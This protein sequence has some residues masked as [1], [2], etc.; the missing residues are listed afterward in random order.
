[1]SLSFDLIVI[2]SGPAGQKCALAAAK[3]GKRVAL[4]DRGQMMGGVCI[5]TGTIPS[6]A[7]R[8][9]VAD[10]V[11]CR[12]VAGMLSGSGG[13]D[14]GSL[15]KPGQFTMDDLLFR[16]HEVIRTER[17]VVRDQMARNNV[18]V[19]DGQASFL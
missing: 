9:A 11:H 16:C 4:V 7:M 6:K 12:A 13:G 15:S 1:M 8:E 19:F 5:H 14:F 17:D 10:L 18:F 3:L 2:G